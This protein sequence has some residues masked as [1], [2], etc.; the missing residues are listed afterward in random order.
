M[1]IARFEF[2]PEAAPDFA[3]LA[4]QQV[5]EM[6]F[7][8]LIDFIEYCEPIEDALKECTVYTGDEVISLTDFTLT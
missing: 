5:V 4:T 8:D 7:N 1:I 3:W 6:R 2:L